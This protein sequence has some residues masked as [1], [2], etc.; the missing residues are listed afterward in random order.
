MEINSFLAGWVIRFLENKDAIR[1]DIV[2]IERNCEGFDFCIE[3]KE[4]TK[5]FTVKPILDRSIFEK[6]KKEGSFGIIALNNAKNIKFLADQWKKAA[7]Y[8]FLSFYFLN[9][10]SNTE[11][12]W[13]IYPYTHNMICDSSS[14]ELG[15][16]SMTEMVEPIGIGEIESKIKMQRNL[17]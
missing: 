15:L 16:K 11:K 2:K 12:I 13:I 17:N 8:K 5:Y 3:Y 1:K 4:K 6:I 14:L 10:F 7:E 9:P